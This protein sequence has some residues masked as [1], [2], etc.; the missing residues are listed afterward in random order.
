MH[1]KLEGSQQRLTSFG[2][3]KAEIAVFKA[4]FLIFQG[5][6]ITFNF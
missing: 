5:L 1:V 2:S 3:S 4:N 6:K